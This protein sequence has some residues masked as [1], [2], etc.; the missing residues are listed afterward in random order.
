MLTIKT[1]L[2]GSPVH[3][4]GL[5]AAEPISKGSIIWKFDHPFDREIP[6]AKLKELTPLQQ[7]FIIN[8]ASFDGKVYSLV[9][10]NTRFINH[11]PTES[12]E[13]GPIANC[14]DSEDFESIVA[15]QDIAEGEEIFMDY[16]L[17]EEGSSDFSTPESSL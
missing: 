4:L 9:A 17:I 8:N 10:D 15:T 3:N 6:K 16:E 2:Q 11:A 14:V 1:K 13:G 12:V 5:F 7:D